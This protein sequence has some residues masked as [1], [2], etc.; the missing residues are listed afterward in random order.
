MAPTV[1][2][3]LAYYPAPNDLFLS[4][5]RFPARI[6]K[7]RW[8]SNPNMRRYRKNAILQRK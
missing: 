7:P 8:N 6:P 3:R 2:C 5:D 1:Y 4:T